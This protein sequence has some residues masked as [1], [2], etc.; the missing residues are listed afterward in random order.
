MTTKMLAVM[1]AQ[2]GCFNCTKQRAKINSVAVD[3]EVLT[4]FNIIAIL[5]NADNLNA[6]I[7]NDILCC[8]VSQ[9]DTAGVGLRK[10]GSRSYAIDNLGASRGSKSI[11]ASKPSPLGIQFSV[12]NC[13]AEYSSNNA[14]MFPEA[15]LFSG[16]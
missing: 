8:L 15:V 14:W 4:C 3:V 2:V 11:V 7:I 1:T 12:R 6:I 5:K 10:A 16:L 9:D 13:R